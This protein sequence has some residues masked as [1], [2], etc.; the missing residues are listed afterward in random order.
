MHWWVLIILHKW[1]GCLWK[2]ISLSCR[3]TPQTINLNLLRAH[4]DSFT[5]WT[6]SILQSAHI[7]PSCSS[8]WASYF[9]LQKLNWKLISSNISKCHRRA[10][11]SFMFHVAKWEHNFS[12]YYNE[13]GRNFERSTHQNT[14]WPVFDT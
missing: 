5:Q 2:D 1:I 8:A 3:W 6:C 13:E 12:Q 10:R 4:L 11:V 7:S 9:I 14:C